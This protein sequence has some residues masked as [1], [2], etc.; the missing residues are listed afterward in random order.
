M[1]LGGIADRNGRA[2]QDRVAIVDDERRLT[3]AEL[4]ERSSRLANGLRR[5]GVRRGD[6]V[7]LLSRNRAELVESYVALSRVGAA[8]VPVNHGLVAPEVA[9][10]L[11]E[12]SAVGVLGE[13]QLIDASGAGGDAR[14]AID[15]DSDEY[16]SL[17][18]EEEIA[19]LPEPGLG[20][21]AVI[22][23]T[24]ATT[25]APKGAVLTHG[26]LMSSSLSWVATARP[27]PGTVFLSA[28]PLFHSTVTIVFGYLAAGA[29]IV[30]MR[31]FSPQLCLSLIDSERAD[32]LY[33]VPSMIDYLLRARGLGETDL[34][35]VTDVIHG[36]APMPNDLRVRAEA[37]LGATLRECY[38]Q[39]EAGGPIT[40]GEPAPH[41]PQ[42]R[43]KIEGEPSTCGRPVLG[44]SVTIRGEDGEEVAAG[45]PGEVWV[46][47]PALMSGYWENRGATAA[48][49]RGSWLL[50][51]DIGYVDDDGYLY[52][53]DRRVDMIIRGGQNVYP[54][55]IERVLRE[56]D[57]VAEAA[58]VGDPD[59]TLQEVPVAYVVAAPGRRPETAE[60]MVHAGER[61][62]SYKRPSRL[63][64]IDSLPRSPAGKVL[65]KELRAKAVGER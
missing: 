30:L 10:V 47:G 6:R 7:A 65:K 52:L 37:A 1:W 56:H 60:L 24:S 40:L 16:R 26:S 20:D 21:M 27:E 33:L 29:T 4:A 50:S 38:G 5:L 55:E 31:Q 46:R 25:G 18:L 28:P 15:F 45:S 63:V 64:F 11:G 35:S 51:G 8:A 53:L 3:H 14:F 54:A 39:A 41:S 13:R 62:A 49:R 12:C 2:L 19:P 9:H 42:L 61:L 59:A 36:A 44:V 48:V 22:L 34:A 58:V 17:A 32:H 23:F 43:A 57:G